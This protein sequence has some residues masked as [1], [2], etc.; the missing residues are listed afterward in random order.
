M[1]DNAAFSW[2]V[3]PGVASCPAG[4]SAYLAA[5]SGYFLIAAR[6]NG[7]MSP[8]MPLRPAPVF[9]RSAPAANSARCRSLTREIR[10]RLSSPPTGPCGTGA[11]RSAAPPD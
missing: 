7:P 6:V 2:A 9:P 4:R 10:E 8:S 3:L 1:A 5:M 11:G